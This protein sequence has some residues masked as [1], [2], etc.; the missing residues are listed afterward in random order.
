MLVVNQPTAIVYEKPDQTSKIE[1]ILRYG[2]TVKGSE[3]EW[4][5]DFGGWIHRDNLLEVKEDPNERANAFVD[6]RGAYVFGVT[7][8]EWGP[9][10]ALPFEAPVEV[11]EELPEQHRRWIKVKLL[12]GKEGF[13]QRSQLLFSKR[14]LSI[15]EMVSFS[16]QFLGSKYLW[17]G[18][19][20]FGYDC[21]GFVQMLYRQA[22]ITIPRNARDQA[23]DGRFID[24]S[25]PKAGDLV[26]FKNQDGK[27]VHVGMM[28]NG[29]EFI[30]AFT[31]QEAWICV[32][33]LDDERF[34]KGHFYSEIKI[35]RLI[36]KPSNHF[37]GATKNIS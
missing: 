28:I 25:D 6:F 36:N 4:V 14:K 9:I 30:H 26:F 10:L 12:G 32:S 22:G 2:T 16:K 8:T 20:S 1:D 23:V 5:F 17:G 18:T 33:R 24:G 37:C 29:E 35:K 13:I 27:V 7:S 11:I 31:K 19:S 3:E 15:E 34:L 21:S